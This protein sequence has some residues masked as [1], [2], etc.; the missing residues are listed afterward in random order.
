MVAGGLDRTGSADASPNRHGLDPDARADLRLGDDA[1]LC[2][3]ENCARG[4]T[5]SAI[6]HTD[7]V[8]G[9]D[10]HRSARFGPRLAATM[11]AKDT[12]EQLTAAA[13]SEF[14]I[15]A[16]EVGMNGMGREAQTN[17]NSTLALIVKE[18]LNDLELTRG[19]FQRVGERTPFLIGE[20]RAAFDRGLPVRSQSL[21]R[22]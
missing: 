1:N 4:G 7:R 8:L 14:S 5:G 10:S 22:T 21:Q 3:R 9:R 12:Y 19:Q 17:S 11:L 6:G 2:R 16:C 13:D 15:E 18:A 20:E